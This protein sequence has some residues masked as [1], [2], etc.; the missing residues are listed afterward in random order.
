MGKFFYKKIEIFAILS[1]SRN[2][3]ICLKRTD[4]GDIRN[5]SMIQNLS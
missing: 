1:Y 4:V 5:P 3:E 2:V